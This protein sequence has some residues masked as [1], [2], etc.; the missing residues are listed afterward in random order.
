MLPRGGG[1][2]RPTWAFSLLQIVTSVCL[3]WILA[4][5]FASVGGTERVAGL[6]I[7]IVVLS[8]CLNM[9]LIETVFTRVYMLN[10][11]EAFVLSQEGKHSCVWQREAMDCEEPGEMMMEGAGEARI[12]Y[13]EHL[14]HEVDNDLIGNTEKGTQMALKRFALLFIVI[15]LCSVVSCYL[16]Y[17]FSK[18]LTLVALTM[19]LC[20]Y[21]GDLFVLRP[22][23]ILALAALT[24]R[25]LPKKPPSTPEDTTTK[26]QSL[27]TTELGTH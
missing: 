2:L 9:A 5:F 23:T 26:Q 4:V 16:N 6:T 27:S 14:W 13:V 21:F 1:L 18:N 10:L 7:L 11:R 17:Q 24:Y 20:G 19:L 3:V 15:T 12:V 25:R 8:C 22:L